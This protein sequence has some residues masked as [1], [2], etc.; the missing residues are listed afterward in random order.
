MY[1]GRNLFLG[2][3]VSR[4]LLLFIPFIIFQSFN[5]GAVLPNGFK[6]N[7]ITKGLTDPTAMEFA[8]DGR[9]FV[10]E[11]KGTLRVIKNNALLR[12]PFLSLT[13]NSSG[14]RGLLGVAFDPNFSDNRYVYVYYTA[15]SPNIHNRVS[16]F[17]ANGDV[18]ESGSEQIILEL[19]RLSATNHNGG[20]I[21]FGSDGKLYVAT[22]ENAVPENAQSFSNLLG[23]ILRIN[24]D[25]TIPTD[26]PFYNSA[27]GVNRAIWAYGLR[28]PFT[29]AFEPGTDRMFIND[30]GSSRFEEV[31]EGIAGSNYGWPATEGTTSDS[32]Y[33]SPIHAYPRRLGCAI[34]GGAFYNPS[35]E[36]FPSSYVGSYFFSDT[37]GG[38]IRR[39]I[40]QR[41]NAVEL[42]AEGL[43]NPVDLK[44]GPDGALYVLGRGDGSVL[45]IYSDATPD[46]IT[47]NLSLQEGW[48]LISLPVQPDSDS[49]SQV[50]SSINSRLVVLY[51]YDA[52]TQTYPV[53]V[54]NEPEN[55]TLSTIRPGAGYW[56]YMDSAATLTVSGI[57]PT[58]S[59]ALAE[60]W[61]LVGYNSTRDR[62]R[63][64]A[65]SGISGRYEAIF[66]YNAT[67]D[68]WEGYSPPTYNSLSLLQPGRG[69]WIYA[70][71]A[72]T[73][74]LP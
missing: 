25:G 31:N 22:G 8:P 30:V 60:G 32:K 23:K 6:E 57:N 16:R 3:V 24:S 68:A 65:L 59:V 2:R 58:R 35:T 39:L 17:R 20:A 48:N 1:T 69:Y 34:T 45:R 43:A 64:D 46:R 37:C 66:A 73:W 63:E 53:Y 47:F 18:A 7:F 61:N 38:W 27:T 21:H 13:V 9:I 71:Q 42:F 70:N 36:Q 10:C 56:V 74:T 29:F 14:E 50:L 51:Q 19:N 11:Q 52:L 62:S 33:R 72:T 15:T 26:N 49:I 41:N 67:T 44:V 54:P 28:N 12:T 40:P 4:T 5:Y 55:S